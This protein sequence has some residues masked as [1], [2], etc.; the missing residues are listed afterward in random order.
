MGSPFTRG[1]VASRGIQDA[2]QIALFVFMGADGEG[3]LLKEDDIGWTSIYEADLPALRQVSA[4]GTTWMRQ[5]N[6][7]IHKIDA[8]VLIAWWTRSLNLLYTEVTDLGRYRGDGDRLDA[9]RA[10]RELRTLDRIIANCV[11]IQARPKDHLS[12]VN[13]SYEF[14]DLIPNLIDSRPAPGAIWTRLANP[15]TAQQILDRAFANAPPPIKKCLKARVKAVLTRFR[16]ETLEH[17]MPGLATGRRI[18]VADRP[19]AQDTFIASLFHQL[20][21]THH[22]Y[23]LDEAYKND[24]LTAHTGHISEAFPELVVLYTIALICDPRP[25]LA[26]DWC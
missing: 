25:A 19:Y 11:R 14:F 17:V 21:N 3:Q 26:G 13:F 23:Q 10:Y 1:F 24:L 9:G 7:T 8:G 22:G 18:V 20:R 12:R 5:T 16:D 2:G 15:A 6:H 4:D